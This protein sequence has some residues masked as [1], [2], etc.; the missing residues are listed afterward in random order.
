MRYTVNVKGKKYTVE[1]K[2]Y[3]I[4]IFNRK[5]QIIGFKRYR[6]IK[7]KEGKKRIYYGEVEI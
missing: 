3:S 2:R 5:G 1:I 4:P 7:L 6:V